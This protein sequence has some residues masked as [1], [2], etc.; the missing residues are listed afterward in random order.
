V[1]GAVPVIVVVS[2][3]AGSG[4]TTV[5]NA[6]AQRLGWAFVEGDHL[7]PD[8]NVAKMARGEPL[9][10][11]DRAP[12]LAALRGRIATHLHAGV[13]AV[14]T[15]SALKR[16][17]RAALGVP[18]ARVLLV[19]LEARPEL[20]ERRLAARGNH[21]FPPALLASQFAAVEPPR[22]RWCCPRRSRSATSSSGS[23]AA[24]SVR[25]RTT[26]RRYWRRRFTGWVR[27]PTRNQR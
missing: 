1:N 25:D 13:P 17:Y 23:P 3:V 19:F 20:V 2:G 10:D 24:C 8:E 7:H 27:P 6:L 14:V 16:S 26:E 15:T 9:S 21:F 12:W 5:G 4:K 11:A 22:M 18:D